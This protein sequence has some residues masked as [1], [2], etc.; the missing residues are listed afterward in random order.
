[1]LQLPAETTGTSL[2]IRGSSDTN[3]WG[4]GDDCEAFLILM[5]PA[6]Q[7][8]LL[9]RLIELFNSN[10]LKQRLYTF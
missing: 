8:S 6:S 1:M 7:Q 9:G 5:V 10:F 3:E 4:T 2:S